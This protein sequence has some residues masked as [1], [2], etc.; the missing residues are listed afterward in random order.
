MSN[1][2]TNNINPRSGNLIT[3][4][5]AND[6]VS[7]A[8]TLTY[9]DVSNIDSV[10]IITAQSGIKVPGGS[11]AIGL[12]TTQ[13]PLHVKSSVAR[14]SIVES[15]STD[16]SYASF[17]DPGTS[18][19]DR[20]QIGSAGNDLVLR[21]T[22]LERLRIDSSGNV[23]IGTENPGTPLT[24]KALDNADSIS[25]HGR[26]ADGIT[27]VTLY[28]SDG[29]TQYGRIQARSTY[30][31]LAASD[32]T[33]GVY[34]DGQG[35]LLINTTTPFNNNDAALLQVLGGTGTRNPKICIMRNDSGVS[36]ADKIGNY[37]IY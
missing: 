31:Q 13:A 28:G 12:D 27:N 2:L 22:E 8:G 1:I 16:G 21:T 14:A 30:L 18:S 23:G 7:I 36:S 9:E 32:S 37:E 33:K 19:Y 10:G 20:V 25:I 15:T 5:G 4:G 3:I 35:R 17:V 29:A 34:I 11:V 6:R 26:N 24:V